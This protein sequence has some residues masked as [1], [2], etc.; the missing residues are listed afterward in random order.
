MQEPVATA[1]A[2]VEEDVLEA[3]GVPEARGVAGRGVI[4]STS[5][6]R[7][8]RRVADG[9][10]V[11]VSAGRALCSSILE[12]CGADIRHRGFVHGQ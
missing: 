8:L 1:V 10:V 12:T 2:C 4:R 6:M 5:K 7:V 9:N 3:V 11:L